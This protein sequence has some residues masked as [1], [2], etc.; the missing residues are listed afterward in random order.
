MKPMGPMRIDRAPWECV[1]LDS[2]THDRQAFSCGAAK[3]DHY[4]QEQAPQDVR[5]DVA[6]V[7]VALARG[8]H[9]VEGYCSLSAASLQR[10]SLPPAQAKRLP[11]YPFPLR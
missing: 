8:S 2:R 3:L 1:A 4:V 7:F 11:H 5:R 6:R 10:S 9:R